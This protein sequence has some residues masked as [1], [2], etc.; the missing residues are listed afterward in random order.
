M[1]YVSKT[2]TAAT[3]PCRTN[4]SDTF[5]TKGFTTYEQAVTELH[6]IAHEQKTFKGLVVIEYT[7]IE[8]VLTISTC[9]QPF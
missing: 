9:R 2:N 1:F 8:N 4:T 7:H 3:D 5:L 6:N